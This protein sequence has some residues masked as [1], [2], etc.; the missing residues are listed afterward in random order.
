MFSLF[1]KEIVEHQYFSKALQILADI[2]K[3]CITNSETHLWF[4]Y[5][6]KIKISCYIVY[7]CVYDMA[8][9]KVIIILIYFLIDI[10]SL[11]EATF[12][13]TTTLFPSKNYEM[14]RLV[15]WLGQGTIFW[16]WVWLECQNVWSVLVPKQLGFASQVL[17][18]H[19]PGSGFGEMVFGSHHGPV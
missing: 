11:A 19:L 10:L 4:F 5:K 13:F 2:L 6:Q 1:T 9:I 18:F 12:N 17:G 14:L 15:M 8:K 3:I 7:I 16:V